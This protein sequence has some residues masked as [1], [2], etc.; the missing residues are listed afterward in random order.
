MNIK[1]K[2][3]EGFVE[4]LM[5]CCGERNV[6]SIMASAFALYNWY[7]SE[8]DKG[9]VVLSCSVDGTDIQRVML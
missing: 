2:V 8:I 5:M 3:E 9:R 4:H 1:V 6:C 7:L